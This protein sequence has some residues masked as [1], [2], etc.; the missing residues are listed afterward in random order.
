MADQQ[1]INN[2]KNLNQAIQDGTAN[3]RDYVTAFESLNEAQ[4]E[5][6]RIAI[7]RTA[8]ARDLSVVLKDQLGIV[9]KRTDGEKALLGVV[10]SINTAAE[11]N[12]KLILSVSEAEK[13]RD[14][15]IKTLSSAARELA[16]AQAQASEQDVIASE[17]I[18]EA[19]QKVLAA[20]KIQEKTQE[21]L[22]KSITKQVAAEAQLKALKDKEGASAEEIAAAEALV[23]AAQDESKTLQ[24]RVTRADK[25]VA[26]ADAQLDLALQNTSE[27]AQQLVIAR[28]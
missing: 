2:Q 6:V 14:N 24:E 26:S 13:V 28:S 22:D 3:I 9:D 5:G 25:L 19:K 16:L 4:K 15:R 12:L 7:E 20:L 10:K 21:R 23:K 11:E 8:E 17:R 18:F 27:A 1:K